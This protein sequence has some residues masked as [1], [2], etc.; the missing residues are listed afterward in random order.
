MRRQRGY[1]EVRYKSLSKAKGDGG[2]SIVRKEDEGTY[3]KVLIDSY[4]RYVSFQ[5]R[6]G[7]DL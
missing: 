1:G 6:R 7:P 3:D 2:S 5:R 4:L